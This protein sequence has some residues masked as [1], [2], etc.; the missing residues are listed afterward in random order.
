MKKRLQIFEKYAD[1]ASE[2]EYW[3]KTGEYLNDKCINVEGYTAE[4]LA[5]LSPFVD[6]EQAFILLAELRDEP[7]KAKARIDRGFKLK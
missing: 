3:I 7:Q 5:K 1:I 6:G 2:F 4:S